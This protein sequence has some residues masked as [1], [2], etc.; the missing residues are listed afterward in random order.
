MTVKVCVAT[1]TL[2]DKSRSV[3]ESCCTKVTDTVK[4]PAPFVIVTMSL[5]AMRNVGV[6]GESPTT[7]SRALRFSLVATLP[8]ESRALTTKTTGES[9]VVVA[10]LG[11]VTENDDVA[12]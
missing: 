10:A 12:P 6:P 9:T 1:K 8:K 11:N 5:P 4:V 3:I 7:A 2:D